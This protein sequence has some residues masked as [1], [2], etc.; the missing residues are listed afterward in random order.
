[1]FGGVFIIVFVGLGLL[2]YGIYRIALGF[3]LKSIKKE[4][5]EIDD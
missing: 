3:K 1:M 5:G 2:F 4:L